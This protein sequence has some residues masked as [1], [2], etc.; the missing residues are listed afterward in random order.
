MPLLPPEV[1]ARNLDRQ[2]PF[3]VAARFRQAGKP[4]AGNACR[5]GLARARATQACLAPSKPPR[6]RTDIP[7]CQQP[8]WHQLGARLQPASYD[9]LHRLTVPRYAPPQP[10]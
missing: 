9:E 8:L 4:L 6:S 10:T 2:Y 3:E 1:Y 7:E 5:L